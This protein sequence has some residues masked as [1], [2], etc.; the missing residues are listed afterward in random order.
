MESTNSYWHDPVELRQR[1]QAMSRVKGQYERQQF[2][3]AVRQ[4]VLEEYYYLQQQA[5][6]A[7]QQR[8]RQQRQPQPQPQQQPHKQQEK[9][10]PVSSRVKQ[11]QEQ[12][13]APHQETEGLSTLGCHS[14]D[15]KNNSSNGFSSNNNDDYDN[16]NAAKTNNDENNN[17]DEQVLAMVYQRVAEC[18]KQ[19]ARRKALLLQGELQEKEH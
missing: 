7:K 8:Q 11:Q 9:E 17:H 10:E 18:A 15:G 13:P 12:L 1:K 3:Q 14:L 5:H 4:T 2:R 19:K 6:E 16:D